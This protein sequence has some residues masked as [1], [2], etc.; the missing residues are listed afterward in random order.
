MLVALIIEGVLFTTV[1]ALLDIILRFNFRGGQRLDN[2]ARVLSL[3]FF[4]TTGITLLAY[5]TTIIDIF[6]I[7][8]MHFDFRVV[9]TRLFV[10]NGLICN[11]DNVLLNALPGCQFTR[12]WHEQNSE[13]LIA[14]LLTV[15]LLCVCFF[16]IKYNTSIFLFCL[17]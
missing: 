12:A 6:P 1:Q 11:K 10:P 14:R 15:Q 17:L 7:C 13:Q 9:R 5:V 2:L 8:F 3:L 16:K 4:V